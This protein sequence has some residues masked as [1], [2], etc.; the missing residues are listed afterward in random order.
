MSPALKMVG[1]AVR[2]VVAGAIAI[3][4]FEGIWLRVGIGAAFA[5]VVGGLL[6][7]AWNVDRKARRPRARVSSES[8]NRTGNT[9][10]SPVRVRR[11][12]IAW[13]SSLLTRTCTSFSLSTWTKHGSYFS[14]VP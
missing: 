8:K 14:A 2:T 1:A 12:A 13:S 7:I 4:L 5:I 9:D 11:C 3:L 6:L 10:Q